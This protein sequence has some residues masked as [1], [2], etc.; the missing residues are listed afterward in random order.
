MPDNSEKLL[1]KLKA[2]NYGLVGFQSLHRQLE[3]AHARVLRRTQ[4]L[5]ARVGPHVAEGTPFNVNDW[6]A[7]GFLLIDVL[8]LDVE[9]VYTIAADILKLGCILL[10]LAEAQKLEREPHYKHVQYLRNSAVRHALNKF[11]GD[12]H[13]EFQFDPQKGLVLKAGSPYAT[14]EDQGYL[15]NYDE[16]A[17]LFDRYDLTPQK[18]NA[19]WRELV[20]HRG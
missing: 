20:K 18:F 8:K 5:E 6:K 3:I 11:S 1:E 12:P 7:E 14:R 17:R 16:L 19:R 15:R 13:N 10:P 4:D 2:K 9:T